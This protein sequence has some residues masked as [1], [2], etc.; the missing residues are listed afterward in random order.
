MGVARPQRTASIT[1]L[2]QVMESSLHSI[3]RS[4]CYRHKIRFEDS[5]TYWKHHRGG[6]AYA[7]D[8]LRQLQAP[9][10]VLCISAVEELIVNDIAIKE[11]WVGFLHQVPRNTYKWYPDLERLVANEH[12]LESL[13]FCRGLFVLTNTLKQYLVEN[14]SASVP[15]VSLLYPFT[16]FGD[17]MFSWDAFDSL[18]P[19]RVL[20]IGEFLRNYQALYDL[21]MP[22]GFQKCL[23]KPP[24]VNFDNLLDCN[25]QRIKIK[26]NNSV[27]LISDRISDDE[28]DSMLSSS[29]IFLNFFD[30]AASTTAIECIG[31]NTPLI[32]NRLPALEEYLGKEYPLFYETLEDAAALF[33]DKELLLKASQYLMTLPIKNKL[34]REYFLMRFASS[35]IYRSLP[36]PPSQASDATQT[37]FPKFDMTIVICSYKRVYNLQHLLE[38]FKSQDY[39]GKFEI[40]LWNNNDKTQEEVA[41]ISAPYRQ[42]LNIRLIQSSQNYYCIVRLAVAKIMQSDILLICDDDVVPK[43]NYLS[44][45]MEK[46]RE[47]GPRVVL[48]C[49]GHV[50]AQH[51]LNDEEPHRFWEDYEYM[52]FYDEKEQDR[53]V[54]ILFSTFILLAHAC[55][56]SK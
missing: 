2:A 12:F 40:I 41:K 24:D 15:V 31:R 5:P 46:Y 7:F 32:V 52:K 37:K 50:F 30:V 42:D 1:V 47:Y 34:T 10:G 49:R 53:Q 27:H 23:I 8:T 9:D 20:F 45:F 51:S 14:I 28:Y 18:S 6:W 17:N 3:P 13:P 25:K 35:S 22:E 43:P 16:P 19:K 38:C 48:C 26:D 56:K 55:Y 44:T 29:I 39:S 54:I 21:K 11:P 33:L 36:L 4:L